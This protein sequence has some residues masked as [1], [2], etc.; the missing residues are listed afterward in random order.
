[1]IDDTE[2]AFIESTDLSPEAKKQ[3]GQDILNANNEGLQNLQGQAKDIINSVRDNNYNNSDV[4]KAIQSLLRIH[5][6]QNNL[7]TT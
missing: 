6:I 3:V 2:R 7:M 4:I 5:A 1:V